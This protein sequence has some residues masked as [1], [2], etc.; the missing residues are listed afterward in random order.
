MA[1][2]KSGKPTSRSALMKQE[3]EDEAR[4]KDVPMFSLEGIRV[5]WKTLAGIFVAVILLFAA[6]G[7]TLATVTSAS[8][9]EVSVS[10]N[11]V[12]TKAGDVVAF[13]VTVQNTA[14][15]SAFAYETHLVGVPPGWTV[16]Q[17]EDIFGL[18]AGQSHKVRVEILATGSTPPNHDYAMELTVLA[19]TPDGARQLGS[20]SQVVTVKLIPTDFGVLLLTRGRTTVFPS[21]SATHNVTFAACGATVSAALDYP[22]FGEPT[23]ASVGYRLQGPDP[24]VTGRIE[25]DLG[26]DGSFELNQTLDAVGGRFALPPEEVAAWTDAHPAGPSNGSLPLAFR[27]CTNATAAWNATL[28]APDLAY[29]APTGAQGSYPVSY[30]NDNSPTGTATVTA[31]VTNRES[32]PITAMV[33]VE[34]L[35]GGWKTSLPDG[36]TPLT[37][38]AN[39]GNRTTEFTLD[40]TK[41]TS[42]GRTTVKLAACQ[43]GN[44]FDC[45]LEDVPLAVGA[46]PYFEVK[47]YLEP[48]PIRSVYVSRPA[49]TL[50]LLRN[51]GN[52]N[53]TVTP[54]VD[55]HLQEVTTS[56]WAGNRTLQTDEPI[57]LS[58]GEAR[59]IVLRIEV[60][61]GAPQTVAQ[62]H[63]VFR[64][65]EN[66][67]EQR[68]FFNV[69]VLAF[70]PGAG[71]G[72]IEVG[73]NVTL[74]Y[75]VST[76]D[77]ALLY[78]TNQAAFVSLVDSGA[79]PTHPAFV[80][81]SSAS[82]A[83]YQFTLRNATQYEG[84]VHE[85]FEPFVAGAYRDES[86]VLWLDPSQTDFAAD[87]PLK[88]A[89]IVVELKVL[90]VTEA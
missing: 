1:R 65:V 8:N 46:S 49:D 77:G 11:F 21:G 28:E 17:G 40:V 58:V 67:Q 34:G 79:R 7:F 13:E 87:H 37:L 52:Q 54:S 50:I 75:T 14:Q 25:V 76:R 72:P 60:P 29:L 84:T 41:N 27:S 6:V 74:E 68:L 88:D 39:G 20:K 10:Q 66:T 32:R 24:N 23:G 73:D 71:A 3:D 30:P 36:G 31:R 86:V 61:A 90:G 45:T 48:S 80:K 35:P 19:K 63:P 22:A 51:L 62:V 70:P 57:T 38:E 43:Q 18:G 56:Y 64:S 12:P 2:S 82:Y 5:H 83:P 15:I 89:T 81:S 33:R 16:Q 78:R 69:N 42:V 4:R 47:A 44:A 26:A 9:F 85:G 59:F 55:A 53:V